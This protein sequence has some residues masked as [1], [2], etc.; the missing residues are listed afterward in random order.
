MLKH[1][2]IIPNRLSRLRKE[3]GLASSCGFGRRACSLPWNLREWENRLEGVVY[4]SNRPSCRR[5]ESS[6]YSAK[7]MRLLRSREMAFC[8]QRTSCL[9][10]KS[11]LKAGVNYRAAILGRNEWLRKR[12]GV[13]PLC[14]DKYEGIEEVSGQQQLRRNT[15]GLSLSVGDG[16]CVTEKAKRS[17]VIPEPTRNQRLCGCGCFSVWN[18]RP[19]QDGDYQG[20]LFWGFGGYL[21]SWRVLLTRGEATVG[22]HRARGGYKALHY[23]YQPRIGKAK[24]RQHWQPVLEGEGLAYRVIYGAEWWLQQWRD[25]IKDVPTRCTG[26]WREEVDWA[27]CELS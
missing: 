9:R 10:A 13:L 23:G 24:R 25:A 8:L 19:S 6:C 14:A 20:P 22:Q 26:E 15:L 12:D 17:G 5:R 21:T 1:S 16:L 18:K 7:S 11:N 27:A 3:R 4:G 2:S